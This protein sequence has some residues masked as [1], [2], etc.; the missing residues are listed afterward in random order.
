M[1]LYSVGGMMGE[2]YVPLSVTTWAYRE[3][4]L[5]PAPEVAGLAGTELWAEVSLELIPEL[6]GDHLIVFPNAY[7]GDEIGSGL[8]DYLD[9]PLWQTVPAVEAGNVHQVTA[10]NSIE[11]Y[12]TTPHL[13][14]AF[15]TAL[16]E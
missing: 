7:G 13:I 6:E 14:Q 2:E 1:W 3:L 15:L 16:E 8:D 11:G 12:W 9:S 4:G 5:T 10:N